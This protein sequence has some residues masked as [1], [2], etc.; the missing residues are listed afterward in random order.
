MHP[1]STTSSNRH[2][3]PLSPR[4][5]G[6][7]LYSNG[8]LFSYDRDQVALIQKARPEWQA[9]KWNGIGG[10]READE[11]AI[12]CQVREFGEETGCHVHTW[13]PVCRMT[14][15]GQWSV[16]FFAAFGDYPI[17]TVTDE[18]VQWHSV[19]DVLRGNLPSIP[20]LQWLLP[21][22]LQGDVCG[23]IMVDPTLTHQRG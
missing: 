17:R 19:D 7:T 22:A 13:K 2:H 4:E 9:G 12:D 6:P 11:S 16:S 20:N 21:M 8:F 3:S 18:P 10:H 23:D 14:L 1:N 15:E 5:G